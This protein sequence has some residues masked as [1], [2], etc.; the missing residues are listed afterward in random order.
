MSQLVA[1]LGGGI[2]EVMICRLVTSSTS[3]LVSSSPAIS[4]VDRHRLVAHCHVQGQPCALVI[5]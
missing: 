5:A 4:W 1:V 3:G 2:S